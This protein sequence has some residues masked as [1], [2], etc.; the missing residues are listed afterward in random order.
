MTCKKLKLIP[1][2]N[3]IFINGSTNFK[4]S[5]SSDHATTDEH[6]LAIREQ[7]NEKA[8]AAGLTVAS[9]KVVQETPTY[10][11][12]VA[13]F[14]RMGETENRVLKKLFDIAHHIAVKGQPFTDFKDHIQLEKING[15]KFQYGLYENESSCKDFIKAIS[16]FFFQKD[17]YEKL[18]RVNFI[19]ILC[20]GTTDTSITEQEVDTFFLLIQT[21]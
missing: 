17:V 18:L 8:I 1:S 12:I 21:S 5:S 13:G 16:K 10:S 3:L 6:T 7:E 9:R 4:M 15:V 2:A 14:K 20:D 19:A 11:A